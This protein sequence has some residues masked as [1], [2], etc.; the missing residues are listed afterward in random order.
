MEMVLWTQ[1][2]IGVPR[3]KLTVVNKYN[4]CA[5][6]L[7]LTQIL[8]QPRATDNMELLKPWQAISVSHPPLFSFAGSGRLLYYFQ[9]F[10][11]NTHSFL[12]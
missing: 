11:S 2:K 9:I 4:K 8:T 10:S 1:P 7:Q 3:G 5:R 12:T 6:C